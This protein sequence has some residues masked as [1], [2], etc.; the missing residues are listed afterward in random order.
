MVSVKE[1]VTV[2][3]PY[4]SK[5]TPEALLEE[6][7]ESVSRQ[8]V[9]TETIVIEDTDQ[10]GPAWARNV[11][12]ERTSSRHVAFLDADDYWKPNKLQ[13]QLT[14][15]KDTGAGL[16]IDGPEM[17]REQLLFELFLGRKID[18]LMSSTVV[19]RTQTDPRFHEGLVT[20][21][22]S[23]YILE[24]AAAV[25]VCFCHDTFD[26]RLHGTNLTEQDSNT[27]PEWVLKIGTTY[28]QAARNRVPEV[29][30][31]VPMWF[32]MFY[33]RILL[34]HLRTISQESRRA[35]RYVEYILRTM[36]R[37]D[38][39]YSAMLYVYRVCKRHT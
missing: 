26:R 2:I 38:G 33:T 3:I 13:R 5:H 31:Y 1:P 27:N 25:D 15:M 10:R 34:L 21:D 18:A 4:S 17:T 36:T 23:L 20:F 9:P 14:A 24:C 29:E 30:K 16:C 28:V 8:S 11:G 37:K 22:D 35:R 12:L 7:K 6:A 19:D 32:V 39:I